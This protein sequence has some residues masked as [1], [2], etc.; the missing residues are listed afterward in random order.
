MPAI[1]MGRY[2]RRLWKALLARL[3]SDALRDL[4]LLP[5]TPCAQP[6]DL[7]LLQTTLEER[8]SPNKALQQ[9]RM[10]LQFYQD[11]NESLQSYYHR[12]RQTLRDIGGQD[13]QSATSASSLSEAWEFVQAAL[14]RVWRRPIDTY[15]P[16]SEI[17]TWFVATGL[18]LGPLVPEDLIEDIQRTFWTYRDLEGRDTHNMPPTDFRKRRWTEPQKYWM[19]R[20]VEENVA[21]TDP[22]GLEPSQAH[23]LE[24]IK[25]KCN[26]AL[27]VTFALIIEEIFTIKAE[28]FITLKIAAA[29][30]AVEAKAEAAEAAALKAE[31]PLLLRL[32]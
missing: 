20:I 12:A 22:L 3:R 7:F 30:E 27:R 28:T 29:A 10:P 25:K 8:F 14:G 17:S 16:L 1:L 9:V 24:A 19:T 21:G 6:D 32:L 15:T 26:A 13:R 31:D 23:T 4:D 11:Q 18:T 5:T 2:G